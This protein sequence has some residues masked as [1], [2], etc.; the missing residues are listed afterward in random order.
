LGTLQTPTGIGLPWATAI[1]A[2]GT[3][4]VGRI[5]FANG[6]EEA[7]R[8]TATAGVQSLGVAFGADNTVAEAVSA[9]GSIVVGSSAGFPSPS[10][11][12]RWTAAT[13]IH[14]LPAMPGSEGAI[15][16]SI[17]HDGSHI[18]GQNFIALLGPRVVR[19]DATGAP[20]DIGLYPG[21]SQTH[22]WHLSADGRTIVGWTGNGGRPFRWI[23]GAGFEPLPAQV[24]NGSGFG[25]SA[26]GTT[27]VGVAH[28]AGVG[29]AFRW[30]DTGGYQVLGL[31]PGAEDATAWRCSADG[32]VV[33][34]ACYFEY[35]EMR[36]FLW[37]Q[38]L[39]MVDLN[40]YLP[41]LGINLD[42]WIL[43]RTAGI[44]A[45]GRTIAGQGKHNGITE[46]WV[47][48][49]SCYADCN[50]DGPLTVADFGCF[51]TRFVAADPYADCN[52]DGAL[53]PA[54]FGCFQGRF[55]AGCP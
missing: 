20:E 41:S 1:S 3:T 46:S 6:D 54:D 27:V 32:T 30:T 24:L 18:G 29:S 33:V 39:G 23:E 26:D 7:F 16:L 34:G 50:E 40:E 43:T 10:R 35:P 2:D 45:D 12:W 28:N 48:V 11:A 31:L 25:T 17:S 4:V 38:K 36:V 55:A 47:A 13:G 44:S 52:A 15:A 21:D 14:E 19:W 53:T 8:W 49:I 42:G 5:R 51:Q 9:D 22:L 37:T